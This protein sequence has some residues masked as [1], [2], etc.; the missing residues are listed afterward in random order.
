MVE[1]FVI[2]GNLHNFT[3]LKANL[4]SS[5]GLDITANRLF[6]PQPR[7]AT[8]VCIWEIRVGAVKLLLSAF[9]G[10]VFVAAGNAFRLNHAD[11]P[12]APATEYLP[13]IDPDGALN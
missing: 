4:T 3:R 5:A 1:T 11:L 13:A 7:T 9:S 10:R 6:G 2:D 8:Y 12:N